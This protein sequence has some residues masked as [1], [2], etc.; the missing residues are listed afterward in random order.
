MHLPTLLMRSLGNG[1]TLHK[2]R[3]TGEQIFHAFN[4]T[5]SYA[6][7]INQ[8]IFAVSGLKCTVAPWNEEKN[9]YLAVTLPDGTPLDPKKTYTVA[10]WEGTVKEEYIGEIIKTYEGKFTDILKEK[11]L[12]DKNIS[13]AKD[14]RITLVWE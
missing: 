7:N 10:F 14:G 11:L 13:P 2:A 9:R 4:D 12:K 1:S 6:T 8:G 5:V 3:M